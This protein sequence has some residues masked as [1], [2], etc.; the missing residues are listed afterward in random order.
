MMSDKNFSTWFVA[1]REHDKLLRARFMIDPNQASYIHQL[2]RCRGEQ[3]RYDSLKA[4]TT[5]TGSASSAPSSAP[6][7]SHFQPY[8]KATPRPS[9]FRIL[10]CIRCGG[11]G[12][13]AA[14]CSVT[15]SNDFNRPIIVDWKGD[16]LVSKS[17]RLICLLFNARGTCS[18]VASRSHGAHS[19]SLCGDAR[20]AA[21]RCPKN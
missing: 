6:K 5:S 7:P 1:W 10:L 8:T 20:H 4:A 19:C 11:M 3:T 13:K 9:S 12:H 2:E 15:T 21:C 18:I 14:N 16:H 17:G